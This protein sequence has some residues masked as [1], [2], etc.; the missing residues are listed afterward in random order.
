MKS[1]GLW[2]KKSRDESYES[3]KEMKIKVV[4]EEKQDVEEIKA[5]EIKYEHEKEKEFIMKMK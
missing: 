4:K 2:K 1:K 5:K 3:I